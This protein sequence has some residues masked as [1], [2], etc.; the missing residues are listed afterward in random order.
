MKKMM[1][2]CLLLTP[3][4]Q[5]THANAAEEWAAKPKEIT[6]KKF[7]F[8][9]TVHHE[10]KE[11]TFETQKKPSFKMTKPYEGDETKICYG[12]TKYDPKTKESYGIACVM[13]SVKISS[14]E[15]LAVDQC[16]N[17]DALAPIKP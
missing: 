12:V 10:G 15:N 9:K 4:L 6:F 1:L 13:S 11:A 16:G 8:L 17:D 5:T 2:L 3:F 7:Q 14:C